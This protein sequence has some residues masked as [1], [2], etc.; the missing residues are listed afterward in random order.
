MEL[1]GLGG[2]I[3][4]AIAAALWLIYLVPNWLRRREYLATELNAVRLQQTIRVLAETSELPQPVRMDAAARRAALAPVAVGRP[5]TPPVAPDPQLLAGRRL[6]RTRAMAS[7]LLLIALVVGVINVVSLLAGSTGSWIVIAGAALTALCSVALLGRLA[8]VSRSRRF[9]VAQA[10]RRTTRFDVATVAEAPAEWTPVAVPKPLYLSR[11]VVEYVE[12]PDAAAL[13]EAAA[14]E[15]E[16]TLRAAPRPPAV[17]SRFAAMGI[18]D[19][20]ASAT[21]DIDAALARRRA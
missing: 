12:A 14:V 19:D 9:P 3:M 10:D 2:G 1:S 13:L 7:L 17:P 8:E 4:L 20:A 5:V 16:Q 6:R 18:V 21:P 15:A 11:A